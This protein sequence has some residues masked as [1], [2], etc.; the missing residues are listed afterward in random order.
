[1]AKVVISITCD[2]ETG[3]LAIK[4]RRDK[5]Y[6]DMMDIENLNNLAGLFSQMSAAMVTKANSLRIDKNAKRIIDKCKQY[7]KEEQ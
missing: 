6:L 7:G 4:A 2:Y 3:K 1:M 5:G